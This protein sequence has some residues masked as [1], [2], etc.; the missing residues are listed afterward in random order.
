M[1]SLH[2]RSAVAL[3]LRQGARLI[4]EKSIHDAIMPNADWRWGR[5]REEGALG[6][7]KDNKGVHQL[8]HS[9]RFR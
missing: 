6:K 8:Q 3:E 1:H 2:Q 5:E 7:K 9:L 4:N